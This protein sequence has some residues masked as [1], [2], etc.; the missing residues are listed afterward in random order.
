MNLTISLTPAEE[1][2]LLAKAREAGTTPEEI[3]RQAIK[4]VLASIPEQVP[5][6]KAPKQSLLGI[7]AQFGPGPSEEEIDQSRAEMTRHLADQAQDVEEL[8]KPA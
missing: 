8:E 3:V 4:P 7:W 2:K 6:V 1:A 5:P